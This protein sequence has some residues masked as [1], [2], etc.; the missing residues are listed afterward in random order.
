[1]IRTH[2]YTTRDLSQIYVGTNQNF[3]LTGP[4][5]LIAAPPPETPE[6]PQTPPAAPPIQ[7]VP[8]QGLPVPTVPQS[9]PPGLVTTQP[10]PGSATVQPPAPA[11]GGVQTQAVVPPL[12]EPQRDLTAPQ[13]GSNAV[14][15]TAQVTVTAPVGDVRMAGGPYMVPVFISGATR[16]STMTVTVSFNPGTLR[17]RTIQEGAFLRQGGA[18][19]TFTNKVDATLGRVDL[20]FVRASDTVGASGSGLLAGITFDAVGTGTS[21]LNVSGVATDPGGSTIPIQFTPAT[22]VVR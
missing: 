14:P 4:P 9:G 11:P 16:V 10:A 6:P 19:V 2:E 20:T 18:S 21:Q 12:S 8:P 7:G 3:G 5:P 15:A 22:V 17:V 13:P 1:V